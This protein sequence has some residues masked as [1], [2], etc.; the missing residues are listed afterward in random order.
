MWQNRELFGGERDLACKAVAESTRLKS[1]QTADG[2]TRV[3]VAGPTPDL[4]RHSLDFLPHPAQQDNTCGP[5]LSRMIYTGGECPTKCI[6]IY[7][8]RTM[9]VSGNPSSACGGMT[10]GHFVEK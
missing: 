9:L 6:L 10:Y 8:Q 7:I 3:G 2:L 1:W 5:G 4:L